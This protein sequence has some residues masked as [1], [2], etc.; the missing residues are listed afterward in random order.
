[1][2][3][4]AHTLS[5]IFKTRLASPAAAANVSDEKTAL[6]NAFTDTS[7]IPYT[8]EARAAMPPK[9][10]INCT[11]PIIA[12]I[13]VTMPDVIKAPIIAGTRIEFEV[14]KKTT[15]RTRTL[16]DEQKDH[17]KTM[18]ALDD[19]MEQAAGYCLHSL[20]NSDLLANPFVLD[21]PL[22]YLATKGLWVQR[23][24]TLEK[25][26]NWEHEL[27]EYLNWMTLRATCHYSTLRS[28]YIRPRTEGAL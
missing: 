11:S 27:D 20:L 22:S 7:R 4:V 9:D 25:Y 26:C 16:T 19:D 24:V 12:D 8:R 6:I 21:G 28:R 17:A 3:V 2:N 13:R 14:G 10:V 5:A 18:R 15:T 1:L 23:L